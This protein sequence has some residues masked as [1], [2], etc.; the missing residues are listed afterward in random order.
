MENV[1]VGGVLSIDILSRNRAYGPSSES[2]SG[3][4]HY[5]NV[6]LVKEVKN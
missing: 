6:L 2:F 1:L 3:Y 4:D 5:P